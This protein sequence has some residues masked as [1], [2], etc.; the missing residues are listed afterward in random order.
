MAVSTANTQL[1]IRSLGDIEEGD[2]I[3]D[4]FNVGQQVIL[5]AFSI[6]KSTL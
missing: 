3:E 2:W 6:L 4:H 5:A 1:V